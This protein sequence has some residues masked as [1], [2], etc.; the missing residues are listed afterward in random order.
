MTEEQRKTLQTSLEAWTLLG[1]ICVVVFVVILFRIIW[2]EESR[3]QWAESL[4][5]VS[6]IFALSAYLGTSCKHD[7]DEEE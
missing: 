4:L 7:L 2:V 1:Q 5:V 3:L 6:L